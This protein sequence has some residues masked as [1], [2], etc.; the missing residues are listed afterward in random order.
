M[1]VVNFKKNHLAGSSG[2]SSR[3][4]RSIAT[5]TARDVV[6][7]PV[8]IRL[9]LPAT[10]IVNQNNTISNVHCFQQKIEMESFVAKVFLT[11][12]TNKPIEMT[13]SIPK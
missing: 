3:K 9:V 6:S 4:V 8:L 10:K 5:W 2:V 13:L 7:G 12:R 1:N 11:N